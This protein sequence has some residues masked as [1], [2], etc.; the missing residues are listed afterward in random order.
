MQISQTPGCCLSFS[1]DSQEASQVLPIPLIVMMLI[2]VALIRLLALWCKGTYAHNE[3][4]EGR[5]RY[6]K[7]V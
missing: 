3:G 7:S 2:V 5:L 4:N 6:L 1:Q